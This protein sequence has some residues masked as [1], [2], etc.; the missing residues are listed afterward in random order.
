VCS[1]AGRLAWRD[2]AAVICICYVLWLL[3]MCP[4]ARSRP[5]ARRRAKGS[6]KRLKGVCG[7]VR[8]FERQCGGHTVDQTFDKIPGKRKKVWVA[9][10]Y[11]AADCS[12]RCW[13]EV[14]YSVRTDRSVL[15]P[16][17]HKVYRL[18]ACEQTC[19]IRMGRVV[20]G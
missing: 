18:S 10:R 15:L 11:T 17:L 2:A 9:R 20:G 13:T 4:D 8:G 16:G 6:R 5:R 1:A 12:W 7:L 3:L 14:T 19:K